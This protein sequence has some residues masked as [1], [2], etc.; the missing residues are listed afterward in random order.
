MVFQGRQNPRR[1]IG[2]SMVNQILGELDLRR[3]QLVFSGRARIAGQELKQSKLHRV[4]V[5]KLVDQ[6]VRKSA[7]TPK[8]RCR[9]V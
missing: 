9:R 3:P 8:A 5:L 2:T 7:G 4:A 6:N 1:V